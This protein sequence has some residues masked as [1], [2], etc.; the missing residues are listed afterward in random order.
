MG[1]PRS[2]LP[3]SPAPTRRRQ[4]RRAPLDRAT[5][6][7]SPA[8]TDASPAPPT[9]AQGQADAA[10]ATS[11]DAI[12]ATRTDSSDTT[13]VRLSED[14]ERTIRNAGILARLA[15]GT[16][17]RQIMAEY[18]VGLAT[19]AKVARDRADLEAGAIAK[20]MQAKALEAL[21]QWEKAMIMGASQGKHAAAR[22]WLTHSKALEPVT[23]EGQSGAK[24][25]IIIGM[26][27]QP[28][29][30]VSLQVIDSARVTRQD[31]S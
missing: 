1:K 2:P 5:P 21:E 9:A 8:P 23:N 4:T 6:P 7:S 16:P 27:G 14:D 20:L 28:V 26:P 15:S 3:A 11:V 22:D 18:H 19:I 25:A 12:E 13:A 17:Y 10:S 31:E 30:G 29:G 24:V